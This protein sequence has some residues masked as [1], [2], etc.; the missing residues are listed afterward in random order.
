MKF[1]RCNNCGQG[2]LERKLRCNCGSTVFIEESLD[3]GKV[4]YSIMLTVPPRGYPD[5]V[6]LN[7]ISSNNVKVFCFSLNE[8]KENEDVMIIEEDGKIVCKKLS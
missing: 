4:I 7:L 1:Y 6:Y 5:N 8:F 2:F 3:R